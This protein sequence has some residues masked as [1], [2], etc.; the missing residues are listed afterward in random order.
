MP[1]C[2]LAD[3]SG[4]VEELCTGFAPSQNLAKVI[5]PWAAPLWRDWLGFHAPCLIW[6]VS[7]LGVTLLSVGDQEQAIRRQGLDL[8]V[9]VQDGLLLDD[10]PTEYGKVFLST[11]TRLH[12]IVFLCFACA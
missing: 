3:L 5:C 9:S 7:L 2:L 6:E 8:A 4:F 12:R 1:P 10:C 11:A